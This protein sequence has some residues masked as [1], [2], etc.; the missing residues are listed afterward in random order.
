MTRPTARL[1]ALLLSLAL[2]AA[3]LAWSPEPATPAPV[4]T[5][6]PARAT[7]SRGGRSEVLAV[8]ALGRPTATP[9]ATPTPARL[10][11]LGLFKVT[12]YSLQGITRSGELVRPGVVATDPA[13]LP[14]GTVLTIEGL[15]GVYSALDTGSGV[16]G[17]WLDVW[18]PTDTQAIQ[19]GVKWASVWRVK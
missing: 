15:P 7:S 10:Q 6:T 12:A 18:M 5:V 16:R 11:A 4:P 13:V 2:V 9:T 17:R 19:H 14:L 3:A 8:R 1:V